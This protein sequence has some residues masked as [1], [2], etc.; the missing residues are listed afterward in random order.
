MRY[1]VPFVRIECNKFI[2]PLQF[3]DNS[4]QLFATI[5]LSTPDLIGTNFHISGSNELLSNVSWNIRS[6]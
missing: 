3:A 4:K 2:L 6:S 1:A 5:G